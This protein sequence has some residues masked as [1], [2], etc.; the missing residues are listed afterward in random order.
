MVL[1]L[2]LVG[3]G[4]RTCWRNRPRAPE[5]GNGLE[6]WETKGLNKLTF[7][8]HSNGL[9]LYASLRLPS[10]T[11]ATAIFSASS[12]ALWGPFPPSNALLFRR[13]FL[14]VLGPASSSEVC[15][16][17][18]LVRGADMT[19]ALET[20]ARELLLASTEN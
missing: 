16:D 5:P 17:G 7:S 6:S 4:I 12:D 1:G 11:Q 10:L 20:G 3:V 8:A 13:S 14:R 18:L 19:R 2:P 9:T 15:V